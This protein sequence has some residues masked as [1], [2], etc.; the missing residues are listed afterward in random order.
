MEIGSF[1]ELQFTKGKEWHNEEKYSA[2]SVA[3]LNSGRAAIFHAVRCLKCDTVYLPYY[4]CETVRL[5]LKRKGIKIKYY[6]ID[7]GFFPIIS[8]EQKQNEAIV[9]VNYFGVMS[10]MH[11]RN[12]AA[13]FKN[14]VIDNAQA[15]FCEPIENCMN[16]YSARKFVGVSDGAYV[17]GK[18]SGEYL[19]DYEQGYS[20]DTSLFLLQRIEYGCESKT[21]ES[22]T[23]N[24]E[25]IDRED[26]MKMSPLTKT[27]LDGTEYWEI[28]ETRRKNFIFA[29]RLLG[30]INKL[31]PLM[32]YEENTVPM[33][34]PLLV[35]DDTLL[36]RLLQAKHFQG[37]WWNYLLKEMSE[38]SFEYWLSR[39]IIPITIDQR[40]G[41]EELERINK[42]IREK[43]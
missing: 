37:H 39:Y 5:F 40:Y 30:D 25:R 24:E 31:N 29:H 36:S 3:R 1:I 21:Y 23:K 27:I 6:R 19:E 43:R 8:E 18:D 13:K 26:I 28:R 16:V 41:K 14:I 42:I 32:Y 9:L 35:E 2:M 22:R 15:F 10:N 7:K 11:M 33:V 38:D 4:Q 17:V 12:L 34:Y 20:S